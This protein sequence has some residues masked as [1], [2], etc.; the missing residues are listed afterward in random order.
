M[1]TATIE[2]EVPAAVEPE[3]KVEPVKDA[4]KVEPDK[5][6][7]I[8]EEPAKVEPVKEEPAARVVPD[9]YD[10]KAP[11]KS[12]IKQADIDAVNAFAKKNKLTQAEAQ[13]AL[14]ERGQ[15]LSSFFERQKAEVAAEAEKWVD[16]VK[17][18][19]EF[20]GTNFNEN[21]ELVKRYVA[22]FADEKFKNDLKETQFGNH[23]GFFK[24]LARAAK[25][26]GMA[27]DKTVHAGA[28]QG[29]GKQPAEK[30]WYPGMFKEEA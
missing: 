25:A 22:K 18:D 2:K 10:L 30:A 28:Q 26:S 23:P 8:K 15:T 21:A 6:D 20:G 5:V 27:E 9:K 1:S 29:S 3:P 16:E 13:I 24:M 17:T 12:L 19:K 4:P 14:E 7:P 11:D